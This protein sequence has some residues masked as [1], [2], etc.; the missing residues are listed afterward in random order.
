MMKTN[1]NVTP[2]LGLNV[3]IVATTSLAPTNPPNVFFV[4]L[5]P[6]KSP[7]NEYLKG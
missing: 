5:M 3:V 7:Q 2:N 4:A 6:N 1:Y